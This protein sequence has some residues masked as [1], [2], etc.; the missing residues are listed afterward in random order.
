MAEKRRGDGVR[1]KK[2]GGKEGREGWRAGGRRGRTHASGTSAT[3]SNASSTPSS[4]IVAP[5]SS[6]SVY[7]SRS[8]LRI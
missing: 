3:T 7:A 4:V 8:N 2:G 5:L 1:M 6:C